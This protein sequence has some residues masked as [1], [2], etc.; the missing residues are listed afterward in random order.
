MVL[1]TGLICAS[2]QEISKWI[3]CGP[4]RGYGRAVQS[5]HF[6][7]VD[8]TFRAKSALDWK[9]FH[10]VDF[11]IF[12]NCIS[13]VMDNLFSFKAIFSPDMTKEILRNLRIC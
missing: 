9:I 10:T 3:I 13:I 11:I 7:T 4:P 6:F 1:G 12:Y 2:G 5:I 8:C